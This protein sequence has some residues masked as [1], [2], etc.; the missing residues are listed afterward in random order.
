MIFDV[1]LHTMLIFFIIL[2]VGF[3]TGK[4]GVI[5]RD[6]MPDFAS[7]ITKI[8]LPCLIFHAT[9]TGCTRQAM[10]DNL[11]MLGLAAAFYATI[12]LMTFLLMKL[13]RLSGDKGRVFMFCFIF[14]NTGFVGIPLMSSLFP[15]RGLLYLSLFGII[16]TPVFWTFGVWLATSRKNVQKHYEGDEAI[17]GSVHSAR[18]M[19]RNVIDII[20]TP[21]IIAM[22]LAFVFVLAEIPV[23][24][25]IGDVLSTISA[26]TSAMCMIYLGALLC[27]SDFVSA[28]KTRELYVGVVV[29]M[30]LIPCCI[31]AILHLTPLS[32]ELVTSITLLAALPTMTIVPMIAS[33]RGDYGDYAA[34]I[35]VATL[36][37]SLVTIPLVTF[38][39]L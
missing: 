37:F 21:N 26:A 34:G 7:L 1:V 30:V 23:P 24:G 2:M 33:Q 10:A 38:L 27:F 31:G 12:I 3:V 5:K 36:V 25:L 35:T 39:V 28:F 32:S 16:D 18:H 19:V 8:L 4:L 22:L 13:L 29:K 9:V 11:P 14:G 15:D 6:F 17:G 20:K